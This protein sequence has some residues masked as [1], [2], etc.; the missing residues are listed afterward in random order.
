MVGIMGHLRQLS[1]TLTALMTWTYLQGAAEALR[2]A[3]AT[4]W[5]D[6]TSDVVWHY[7]LLFYP[8]SQEVEM[9]GALACRSG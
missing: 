9:V 5:L 1:S 4:E 8:D 6:P 3:F 2:Y 7:Q